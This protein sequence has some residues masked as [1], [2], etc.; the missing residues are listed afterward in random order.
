MPSLDPVYRRRAATLLEQRKSSLNKDSTAQ[1]PGS[2]EVRVSSTPDVGGKAK[3][4]EEKKPKQ[5][6]RSR[7]R[8]ESAPTDL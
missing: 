7:K 8:K 5:P 6:T 1:A 3:E 2:P 4:T